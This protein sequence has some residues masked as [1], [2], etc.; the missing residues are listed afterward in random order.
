MT[1]AADRARRLGL[2]VVA[3]RLETADQLAAARAAG[4][5]YGQGF[6]LAHPAPADRIGTY[7]AGRAD[8]PA[9]AR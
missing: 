2:V 3:E 6:Q 7:L 9:P 8:H 1:A 4:C 5:R